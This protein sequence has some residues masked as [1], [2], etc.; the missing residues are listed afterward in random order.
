VKDFRELKVWQKP[1][2]L[3]LAMYRT[4]A[5]FP[6]EEMYGLTSQIRRACTSIPT[7]IAEGCGRGTDADFAHF[8][9]IAMGSA[10]ETEY[11]LLLSRNLAYLSPDDYS[12]LQES[13][14][15]V[16]RMISSLL[17]TLRTPARK[18]IADR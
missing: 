14:E 7:N 12:C 8:L 9:Q 10:C 15:E 13:L 4:T 16:K 5:S 18:L 6:R 11:Q 1:H 17:R 2:E 3:T